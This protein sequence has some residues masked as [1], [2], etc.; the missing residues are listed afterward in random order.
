MRTLAQTPNIK[1][2]GA[3]NYG[4]IK[5]SAGWHNITHL[6]C[7]MFNLWVYLLCESVAD[8]K[9]ITSCAICKRDDVDVLDMSAKV[10]LSTTYQ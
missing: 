2:G 7:I 10:L 6:Q 4:G 3:A 9:K 1:L 5:E 8:A